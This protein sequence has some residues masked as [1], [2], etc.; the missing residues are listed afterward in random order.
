MN[1]KVDKAVYDSKEAWIIPLP[2][3]KS[4]EDNLRDALG[5]N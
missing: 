2:N 1:R 4:I 5:L 3:M